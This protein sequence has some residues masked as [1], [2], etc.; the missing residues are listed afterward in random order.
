MNF[1]QQGIGKLQ[2]GLRADVVWWQYT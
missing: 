1:C 2:Q